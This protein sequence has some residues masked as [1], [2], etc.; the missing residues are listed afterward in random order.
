MALVSLNRTKRLYD[1]PPF[2]PPPPYYQASII[3]VLQTSQQHNPQAVI[4][5]SLVLKDPTFTSL[6][7]S[8]GFCHLC[9]NREEIQSD[10]LS[11]SNCQLLP[12]KQLIQEKMT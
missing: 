3:C 8:G 10:S 9:P 12:A 2:V 7:E 1:F 11:T 4:L 5:V 6:V